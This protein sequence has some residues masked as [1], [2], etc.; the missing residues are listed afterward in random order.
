MIVP[1]SCHTKRLTAS[2]TKMLH[3]NIT[4]PLELYGE[5]EIQ[6]LYGIS[7]AKFVHSS[8]CY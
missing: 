1:H 4:F 2:S 6:K 7:I 3:V 8:D 5:N